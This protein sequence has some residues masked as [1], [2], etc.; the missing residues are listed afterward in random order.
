VYG[1]ECYA[2]C[3]RNG[4]SVGGIVCGSVGG[5]VYEEWWYSVVVWV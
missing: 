3:M 4:G 2:W 5:I 1:V